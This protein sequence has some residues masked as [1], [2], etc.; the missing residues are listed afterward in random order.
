MGL[1]LG[2]V[3][4]LFVGLG[5]AFMLPDGDSDSHESG[6][7]DTADQGDFLSLVEGGDLVDTGEPSVLDWALDLDVDHDK[8]DEPVVITDVTTPDEV[9]DDLLDETT[10]DAVT[11]HPPYENDF[12][13][14]SFETKEFLNDDGHVIVG[15]DG[16]DLL[17]GGEGD[18]RLEGVKGDDYLFG[19]NGA[20]TLSGGEGHD[21]IVA[22]MDPFFQ[23]VALRS[24]LHGNGGD[25]TLVGEGGDLFSG[26]EGVDYFH[27]FVDDEAGGEVA[28]ITDFDSSRESLLIEVRDGNFGGDVDFDVEETE[29][30][31]EV[32]I[33]GELIVFLEGVNQQSNLSI[34]CRSAGN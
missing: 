32:R 25:D 27:I 2:F 14:S 33:Q 20:D 8:A 12:D 4:L 26:G 22:A 18:D 6:E 24:E 16:R 10:V 17:V 1:I 13:L 11:P 3:A 9:T 31:L 23:D 30:G 5:L 15:S 29:H 21:L 34:F 19:G 28:L 7:D